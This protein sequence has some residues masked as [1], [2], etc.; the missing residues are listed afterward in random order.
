M[1]SLLE[2]T[3]FSRNHDTKADQAYLTELFRKYSGLGADA[4][5]DANGKRVMTEFNA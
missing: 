4:D 5:N 1:N 2:K 3:V